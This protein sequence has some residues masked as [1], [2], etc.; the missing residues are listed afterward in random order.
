[1][2]ELRHGPVTGDLEAALR[3]EPISSPVILPPGTTIVGNPLGARPWGEEDV[4][5]E[6]V[7]SY[8]SH[9][10]GKGGQHTNGPDYGLMTCAHPETGTAVTIDTRESRGPHRAR[11]L[12]LSLCQM[13]VSELL[14]ARP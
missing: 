2:T 8:V 4:S 1:M 11:E 9:T 7:F 12:A 3:G 14:G 10:F 6:Y 13:A 5:A